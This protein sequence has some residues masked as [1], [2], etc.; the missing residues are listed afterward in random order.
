MEFLAL[1]ILISAIILA[2]ARWVPKVKG[3][4]PEYLVHL[5]KRTEEDEH[6]DFTIS[7]FKDEPYEDWKR[8]IKVAAHMCEDRIKFNN[9]RM[10]EVMKQAQEEKEAIKKSEQEEKAAKDVALKLV[11]DGLNKT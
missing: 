9:D 1:C 10:L 2:Y 4:T 8:R 5:Q 11:Q 7:L 3:P 6:M